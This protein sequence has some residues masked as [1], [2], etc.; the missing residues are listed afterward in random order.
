MSSVY[1]VLCLSHDPAIVA[2]DCDWNDREDAEAAIRVGIPGHETCD[3]LIGR[4]SY[5]LIAVGCP[6]Q[7]DGLAC[8]GHSGTLWIDR[9]WLQLLYQAQH[10]PTGKLLAAVSD[11]NAF[12]CWTP[13][14]LARIAAELDIRPPAHH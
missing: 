6:P 1:R 5:P 7:R 12:R 8:G 13:Q 11:Q 2:A 9:G 10:E 3:L 4:Y 14:R